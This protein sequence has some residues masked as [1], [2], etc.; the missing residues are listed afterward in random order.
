MISAMSICSSSIRSHLAQFSTS[1]G[2]GEQ[3]SHAKCL[4]WIVFTLTFAAHIQS[5]QV[6]VL[7]D[8]LLALGGVVRQG[9]GV[10]PTRLAAK[11]Q[12][13]LQSL[14]SL[15]L[16]EACG[17]SFTV[18]QHAWTWKNED[19]ENW[20]SLYLSDMDVLTSMSPCAQHAAKGYAN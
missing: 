2:K 15:L 6:L 7:Q 16:C 12:K 8:S 10:L 5:S 19:V 1:C 17:S 3:R 9:A 20:R 11:M 18:E 4:A 13:E 14:Q